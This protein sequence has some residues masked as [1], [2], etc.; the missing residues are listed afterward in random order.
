MVRCCR[1]SP[2][3]YSAEGENLVFD[4]FVPGKPPYVVEIARVPHALIDNL[5]SE[6]ADRP[7]AP[8]NSLPNPSCPDRRL[9]LETR[10]GPRRVV[11][12]GPAGACV[13]HGVG[14]DPGE[15]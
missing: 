15:R 7:D 13:G 1:S 4:V 8:D 3:G 10:E 14:G 9:N 5:V 11:V 2:I 12:G 6:I